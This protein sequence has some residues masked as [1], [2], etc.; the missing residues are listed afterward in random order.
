MTLFGANG[1]L[2]SASPDT[3]NPLTARVL[4]D[5]KIVMTLFYTQSS[6]VWREASVTRQTLGRAGAGAES[7][8]PRIGWMSGPAGSV[9]ICLGLPKGTPWQRKLIPSTRNSTE[10]Y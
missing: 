8:R 3:V 10:Q 2:D 7:I 4:L 9:L 1:G 6:T 5:M